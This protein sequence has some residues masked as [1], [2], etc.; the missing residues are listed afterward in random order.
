MAK[1]TK[2][3]IEATFKSLKDIEGVTLTVKE[4]TIKLSHKRKNTIKF[5]FQWLISQGHFIGSVKSNYK[6]K[7]QAVVSMASNKEAKKFVEAYSTLIELRA[8][9]KTKT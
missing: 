4:N 2:Q 1:N 7:N 5:T 6:S 3:L 9:K 8:N